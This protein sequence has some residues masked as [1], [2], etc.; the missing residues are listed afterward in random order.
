MERMNVLLDDVHAMGGAARRP[1]L[2]ELGHTA[3]QIK[4]AV[5]SG[6]LVAV[7]RSWVTVPDVPRA[8]S[9][10]LA[11][12]GVVGGSAALETYGVWVTNTGQCVVAHKPHSHRPPGEP[13]V[14]HLEGDFSLDPARRWRVCLIDA[15]TQHFRSASRYDA[16]AS[17]DSALRLGLLHPSDLPVLAL[18][19]PRRKR[20][21]LRR[22]NANADS[23]L[24]SILRLAC[25]DEGWD[26][27]VQVPFHGGRID[28][29][30]NGWLCIEIDGSQF[31]DVADQARKDRLRNNRIAA[32]GLRWHRFSYADIVH[33]LDHTL[34]T[35]RT[36]LRQGAPVARL[37]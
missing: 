10:A 37:G 33:N 15:L 23:G 28:M 25:E 35:I 19:L 12:H 26:V 16:I 21:W 2:R 9:V 4:A 24:E 20:H 11:R 36:M 32:A 3:R 6:Q 1:H 27:Q 7:S 30:I 31:H 5:D 22:V 17:V 18:K 13:G 34:A 14:K 8:V 29:V